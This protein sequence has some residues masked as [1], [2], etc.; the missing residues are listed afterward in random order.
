MG[1]SGM[2][3]TVNNLS[4]QIRRETCQVEGCN[5]P[6]KYALY[7]LKEVKEWLHVCDECD[8]RIGADNERRYKEKKNEKD[9]SS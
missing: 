7:R 2:T 5:E 1:K 3:I 9:T 8:K 4:A 6:A